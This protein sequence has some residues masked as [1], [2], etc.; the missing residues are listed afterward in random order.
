MKDVLSRSF[1]LVVA[2]ACGLL[3]AGVQAQAVPEDLN[4]DGVA[5]TVDREIR[6]SP[7]QGGFSR[8]LVRSGLDGALLWSAASTELNDLFGWHAIVVD[9]HDGDGLR[10]LVVAAPWATAH[11]SP[12][13]G[14]A[15]IPGQY[16]KVRLVG[17]TNGTPVID[18]LLRI[19]H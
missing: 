6:V 16:G 5:D 2:V 15:Q 19:D 3:S 14:G 12:Q 1:A 8:I 4:A 13:S 9:D 18:G 11:H 10:D 17:S 7:D